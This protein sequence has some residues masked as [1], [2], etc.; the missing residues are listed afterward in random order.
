MDMLWGFHWEERVCFMYENL[1]WTKKFAKCVYDHGRATG[2][3]LRGCAQ[4]TIMSILSL[5]GQFGLILDGVKYGIEDM[6]F[7]VEEGKHIQFPSAGETIDVRWDF[8]GSGIVN[9]KGRRPGPRR[10]T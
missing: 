3:Q 8:T 9:P 5:I 6:T 4:R 7:S 10:K 1:C 2:F